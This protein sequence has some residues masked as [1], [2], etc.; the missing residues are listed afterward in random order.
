MHL[1]SVSQETAVLC[2]RDV[3]LTPHWQVGG[4]A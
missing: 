3:K 4:V 2:M 1:F